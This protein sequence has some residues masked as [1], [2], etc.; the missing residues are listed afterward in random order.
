MTE[1]KRTVLIVDDDR[2][3]LRV[4]RRVL[5]KAGYAVATAETGKEAIVQI[6]HCCFD[7]ALIDVKLPDVE[8]IELLPV[9]S[10]V[11]PTTVR[12]VFTGSPDLESINNDGKRLMDDFLNKPVRPEVVLELLDRKIK[13]RTD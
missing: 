10:G 7:A 11:S 13:R 5:E 3:I 8:G 6:K 2:S 1:P 4:F 9:I 12:I